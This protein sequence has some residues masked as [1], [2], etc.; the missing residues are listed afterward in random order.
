MEDHTL[1][2][3]LQKY[4]T[5]TYVFDAGA[6]QR[7]IREVRNILG[8]HIFLCY[9]VKANPFL[10]P[11]AAEAADRLEVCSPGELE[12]CESLSVPMEKVVYSGVNKEPGDVRQAVGD[13][14]G[15]CTA[16]SLRHVKILNAEALRAG[17]IIPVLLRLNHGSQF[18][19]SKENLLS[20]IDHRQEYPGIDIVGIHYFVGTQRKNRDLH[21]QK[22]ELRMLEDLFQ[23]VREQHGF[24]LQKLEYGPGLPVPLFAGDDFSDTLAPARELAPALQY[25]AEFAELTVEAGRFLT[26]ECG[27]YLTR[28]M[29]LKTAGDKHYCIAD[30]G[31]HHVNYLGQLM[32]MK[33]PVI[34]HYQGNGDPDQSPAEI[35]YHR[36]QDDESH[37]YTLCGSLCTTNDDLVRSVRMA[38]LCL[39]DVLAFENIGAYSVTEAMYLFLSRNLPKIVL[40]QQDG[41]WLLARDAK[42]TSPINTV[43]GRMDRM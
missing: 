37:E 9:S 32:G 40:V 4:G 43:C 21:Q 14:V 22:D 23:E 10:I 8:E 24:V 36:L 29:D 28:V 16:E 26:T 3:I 42:K 27:F 6:F 19:M 5:P 30:G 7:R 18:G 11:A 12:I 2:G 1:I 35:S 38:E 41:S 20:V 33:L 25:V 34:R 15:C 13:A 39:G 31:I 17:K